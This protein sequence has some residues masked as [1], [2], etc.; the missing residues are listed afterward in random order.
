M[1]KN[2]FENVIAEFAPMFD[3]L[4][5]LARDLRRVL[6]PIRDGAIFTGTFQDHNIM[7]DG[8]IEAFDKA[9]AESMVET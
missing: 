7:Y 9:I 3:E 5:Q 8:M 4:K 2:R 1:D 6:F